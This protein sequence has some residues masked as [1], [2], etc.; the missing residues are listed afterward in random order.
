V[1]GIPAFYLL[2]S[3]AEHR[4]C[5]TRRVLVRF[6]GASWRIPVFTTAGEPVTTVGTQRFRRRGAAQVVPHGD[7]AGVG[8]LRHPTTPRRRGDAHAFV[9]GRVSE[10]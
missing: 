10:E 5:V 2:A 8:Q 3:T 6:A 9:T 1:A 4:H 7:M